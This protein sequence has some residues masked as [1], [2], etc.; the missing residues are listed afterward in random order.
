MSNYRGKHRRWRL[1][2]KINYVQVGLESLNPPPPI[3]VGIIPDLQRAL[4]AA[5]G[6]GVM[7]TATADGWKPVGETGDVRIRQTVEPPKRPHGELSHD[8][9]AAPYCGHS[10]LQHQ[11]LPRR[12]V[13]CHEDGVPHLQTFACRPV[14]IIDEPAQILDES[15]YA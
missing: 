4:S 7:M 14:A 13:V 15:R 3:P 12:W 10:V 2:G 1:K 6:D 11:G 5:A 9:C 8:G